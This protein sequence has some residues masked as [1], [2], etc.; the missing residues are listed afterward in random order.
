[1]GE[2]WDTECGFCKI[3]EVW[4]WDVIGVEFPQTGS[5]GC[6]VVCLAV[7]MVIGVSRNGEVRGGTIQHRR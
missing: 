4:R 7:P 1:M 3:K 2:F 6:V 5:V